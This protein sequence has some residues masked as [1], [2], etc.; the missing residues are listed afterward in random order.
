MH[1]RRAL[2]VAVLMAMA[3]T[4]HA[5]DRKAEAESLFEEGRTLMAKKNVAEACPKFAES[6]RLEPG[7]GTLLNL[8]SCEEQLG[9]TASAWAHYREAHAAATRASDAKRV[10]FAR[11]HAEALEKKLSR[12]VVTVPEA[13]RLPGLAVTRDGQ[14]LGEASW[15]SAL[16]LDPGEHVIEARAEKRAPFKTTVTLLADADQKTVTVPLLEMES[17]MATTPG[18]A[19]PPPPPAQN[20][21]LGI[22]PRE[23]LGWTAVGV[24]GISVAAGLIAGLVAMSVDGDAKEHCPTNTTCD[25]EGLSLTEE[26]HEAAL[27]STISVALGTA[28]LAAGVAVLLFWPKSGSAPKTTTV[29]WTF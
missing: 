8:A 1:L 27:G 14:P 12:L 29:G 17:A 5:Q 25:R 15:G 10:K 19:S 22:G 2:F 23:V 13:N 3:G 6:Y 21:A 4:A 7:L 26:A 9:K 20:D 18:S 28:L 11:E 16:A 24:G